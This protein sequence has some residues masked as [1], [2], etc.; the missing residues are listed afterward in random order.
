[1]P[2]PGCDPGLGRAHGIPKHRWKMAQNCGNFN[3]GFDR[4]ST[5]IRT[6][7][8]DAFRAYLGL[9]FFMRWLPGDLR[10]P[11]LMP[12]LVTVSSGRGPGRWKPCLADRLESRRAHAARNWLGHDAGPRAPRPAGSGARAG[13]SPGRREGPEEERNDGC[14]D[15]AAQRC[16]LPAL[17]VGGS[18][19]PRLRFARA[20]ARRRTSLRSPRTSRGRCSYP[21]TLPSRG[22]RLDRKMRSKA[23]RHRDALCRQCH[24][25][26]W[27]VYRSPWTMPAARH[28]A[29]HHERLPRLRRS[30]QALAPLA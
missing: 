19:S 29:S 10:W 30:A 24:P 6:V 1:M 8:S 4:R 20:R 21:V 13:S 28:R 27:D 5:A 11:D 23:R 22:S 16:L 14:E 25:I 3:R 15:G 26:L 12:R 18:P 7:R 9:R 2:G 17:T